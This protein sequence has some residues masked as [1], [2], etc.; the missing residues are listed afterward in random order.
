MQVN[1]L[2]VVFL[3]AACGIR[4][5]ATPGIRYGVHDMH[6]GSAQFNQLNIPYYALYVE[7]SKIMYRVSYA[8]V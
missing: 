4:F 5:V 3:E 1:C 6:L 8:Y 7:K 2:N